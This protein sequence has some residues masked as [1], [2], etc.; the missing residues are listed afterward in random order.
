MTRTFAFELIGKK[1]IEGIDS[2]KP[3]TPI[4]IYETD[5]LEPSNWAS[6]P[7][8]RTTESAISVEI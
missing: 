5:T 3:R 7:L 2:P 4:R 6:E 1:L 8:I